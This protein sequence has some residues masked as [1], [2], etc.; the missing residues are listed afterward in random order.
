MRTGLFRLTIPTF[1]ITSV[2][3]FREA[4]TVPTGALLD[5]K[6]KAFNGSS[7]MEVLIEGKLILMFTEDLIAATVPA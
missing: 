5:L 2:N 3:G 4:L 7:L 1:G 6:G